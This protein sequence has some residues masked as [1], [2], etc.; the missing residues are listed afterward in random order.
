MFTI[1]TRYRQYY[2]LPTSEHDS[3]FQPHAYSGC[4][5][6]VIIFDSLSVTKIQKENVPD[7]SFDLDQ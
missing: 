5:K 7:L 6:G 2:A 1:T 4:N 3:K